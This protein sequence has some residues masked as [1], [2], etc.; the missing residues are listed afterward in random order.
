MTLRVP[1]IHCLRLFT[2]FKASVLLAV[3]SIVACAGDPQTRKARHFQAGKQHLESGKPRDAIIELRNAIAIDPRFGEARA[4]LAAVYEAVGDGPNALNE[5]VRA[6]DLLPEDLQLQ[7]TTGAY[8]L[9]ARRATDALTRA[10]SVLAQDP[11]NIEGHILKGNAL[12]GVNELDKA[13]Q[14]MEEALRLDPSRGLTYTQ[15][16]LVESARGQMRAAEAA[17][18]RAVELAPDQVGCHLALANFYWAAGR[19]PE[20][21]KGLEAALRL[22]PN[23]QGTNRAL[24]VFSLAS[25]RADEAE[26]YLVRIAD[27]S[28]KPSSIFTL[29]DYY[30][31]TK[32]SVKAVELLEPLASG[33]GVAGAQERLARAYAAAGEAAKAQRLVDEILAKS[34]KDAETLLLKGQLLLE[35]NQRETALGVLKLAVEADPKALGAR[36]ALG[37]VYAAR[38]DLEGAQ[39]AFREVLRQNPAANAAR[40]ELSLLQLAYGTVQASLTEAEAVVAKQPGNVAARLAL[41]RGLLAA[42]AFDRADRELAKLRQAAPTAAAVHVQVGVLAASRNEIPAARAAFD[43]ALELDASSLE[44]LAGLLALDLNTKNFAAVKERIDRV[45]VDA[46][47]PEA[48]LLAGRTYGSLKDMASAERVLRRAIERDPTLLPAYSMLAQVY[49]SQNKLDEA[50][51]EFDSLASRQSSPAISLTMSGL[52][53]QGQGQSELARKRYEE[54]V[55]ADGRAVV[56]ANNLAW[57]YA[58]SG[59]ELQEALRLARAAAEQ[60]PEAPEVL[61]TLGW[62][63]Y[64]SELPAMAIAPLSRAVERSP[65]NALYHYHLGLALAK[66]NE[67]QRSRAAFVQAISLDRAAA[68]TEDARRVIAGLPPPE[69]K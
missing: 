52:I 45:S 60:L 38:G 42:R 3:L 26:K 58:E 61:D 21:E 14:E 27:L 49:F 37:K 12:G 11:N 36:F 53:L 20:A 46:V 67:P 47:S 32:R 40:V 50:R 28:K 19:L 35:G 57:I 31:A 8:L 24:A 43:Q 39:T 62:V 44:A 55:R 41:V 23:N 5:Y 16:G 17:F 66:S 30:V 29:A 48:L 18:K 56:A 15:L 6:A 1:G 10:E 13:L 69:T 51:K 25:G 54:A 22:D 2:M 33:A 7:I 63:Y 9:A 65:K 34:P 4:K 64:K 59:V 68:W